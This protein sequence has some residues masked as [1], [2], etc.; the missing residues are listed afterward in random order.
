MVPALILFWGAELTITE[1]HRQMGLLE[2]PLNAVLPALGIVWV[3]G[4]CLEDILVFI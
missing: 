2:E 3:T 1:V 4:V